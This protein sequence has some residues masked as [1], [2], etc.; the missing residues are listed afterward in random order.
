MQSHTAAVDFRWSLWCFHDNLGDNAA[1]Y[2][3]DSAV[4][5]TSSH[6]NLKSEMFSFFFFFS[7]LRQVSGACVLS[8]I[9][10]KNFPNS[11]MQ[12]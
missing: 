5:Q 1:V 9:H 10:Y 3:N 4:E 7:L 2:E 12:Q 6:I 11:K 8:D